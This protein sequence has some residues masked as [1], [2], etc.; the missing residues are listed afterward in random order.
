MFFRLLQSYEFTF[1][2]LLQNV[3]I[4]AWSALPLLNVTIE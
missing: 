2:P 4:A 1:L 3:S